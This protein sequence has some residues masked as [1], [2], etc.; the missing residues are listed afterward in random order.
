LV[1]TVNRKEPNVETIVREGERSKCGWRRVYVR[2][3]LVLLFHMKAAGA[4]QSQT[5]TRHTSA[6]LRNLLCMGNLAPL[7]MI[8][9]RDHSTPKILCGPG[10]RRH[11]PPRIHKF[12][13]KFRSRVRRC[14]AATMDSS[15]PDESRSSTPKRI[16]GRPKKE[17]VE[18]ENVTQVLR[19]NQTTIDLSRR[20]L[21]KMNILKVCPLLHLAFPLM[22]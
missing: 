20:F 21:Q 5:S 22:N 11:G 6:K 7:Q 14:D 18:R 19:S 2:A 16:R 12:W 3:V 17:T 15:S 10:P 8:R 9:I 4:H 13:L 1:G